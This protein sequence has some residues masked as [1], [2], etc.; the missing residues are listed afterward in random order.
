MRLA[1]YGLAA[2]LVLS[3]GVLAMPD[4]AEAGGYVG[5]SVPGFSLYYNDHDRYRYYRHRYYRPNYYYGRPY[6]RHRHYR[7]RHHRHHHRRHRHGWH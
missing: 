1:K 2:A 3:A 5:F 7:H 4:K 6:Y